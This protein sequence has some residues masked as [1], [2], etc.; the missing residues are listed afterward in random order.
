MKCQ[1][2]FAGKHDPWLHMILCRFLGRGSSRLQGLT[3]LEPS[4]LNPKICLVVPPQTTRISLRMFKGRFTGHYSSVRT[5]HGKTLSTTMSSTA[6]FPFRP[7]QWSVKKAPWGMSL[8]VPWWSLEVEVEGPA[9]GGS[10]VGLGGAGPS[11][12]VSGNAKSTWIWSTPISSIS[13]LFQC[14]FFIGKWGFNM[15]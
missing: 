1:K 4:S 10:G 12:Q 9:S 14:H 6:D 7:T 11:W 5:H 2:E 8:T 3:S 15:F 13:I